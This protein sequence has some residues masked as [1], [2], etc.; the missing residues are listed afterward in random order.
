M[1]PPFSNGDALGALL[2]LQGLLLAAVGLLMVVMQ[3]D[4]SRRLVIPGFKTM[5]V[6]RLVSLG[7]VLTGVGSG[8]AWIAVF[9]GGSFVDWNRVVVAG[10]A[11]AA[12][13]IMTVV[14]LLLLFARRT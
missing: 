4:Q 5:A 12:I 6:L 1:N 8:A 7:G 11:L 2:A 3:S 9:T 14:T 10:A 13:I